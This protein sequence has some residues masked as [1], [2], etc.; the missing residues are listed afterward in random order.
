[1]ARS[2]GSR[3]KKHCA[4][5]KQYLDH[6]DKKN[7]SMRCFLVCMTTNS[8]HIMVVPNRFLKHFNGKLSGTIKLESPNGRVYDVQVTERF[9]KVVF[10]HGWG[11]FVDAH[12]IE[13]NDYLLFRHI[14]KSCFEALIFDS[15]G[16][17]KVFSCAG[18][19]NT[20]KIQKR[21]VDSVDIS[22]SSH[23]E[24]TE[25]SAS[26]RFFRCQKDSMRLH[27]KKAKMAVTSSSSEESGNGIPSE[28]ESFESDDLQ[29]PTRPDY[30]LSHKSYLSEAQQERVIALIQDIQPESTVFVAV[31]KKSHVEPP[32]T[33]LAINKQYALEHFPHESTNI[34]LQRPGKS[35]KWHPKYYK[36][37]DKCVHMLRGQWLD[38][39]RDNHVKVG[40]ICLFFPSK[41]AR[42]FTFTVYIHRA[43]ATR[44][45][46][47]TGFQRASSCHGKS[48]TKMASEVQIKEE[49]IDGGNVSLESD[50]PTSSHESMASD[51]SGPSEPP[52][53]V[54]AKSCLSRSQKRIVEERVQAIQ[55]EAPIFVAIMNQSHV[56]VT[57]HRPMIEFGVRFA[58]PH[59]PHSGQTVVLQCMRRTWEAN[60]KIT[61]TSS[62]GRRR[63]FLAGGWATFVRDNDL[64]I[65]DICLFELKKNEGELTM[66]VHILFREQF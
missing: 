22:S 49:P 57:H 59:L 18:I 63:W 19:R 55:S 45:C 58:A 3:M 41:G 53:I 2:G 24:T 37:E 23:H 33:Y 9:S 47:G 29:T 44:S 66:E 5:C 65:G 17:E 4:S 62:T 36:R 48:S 15:D 39:V 54:P 1:M 25:S 12:H 6:L 42:R 35:K 21:S 10:R 64:R 16:C 52:Y 56:S 50:M 7:Q 30:V 14:G 26:Q 61:T 20:P 60:M 28:N 46:G 34:T 51:S 11:Q 32:S 38:F 40:D 27:A 31:M 13:E 43:T 8:K